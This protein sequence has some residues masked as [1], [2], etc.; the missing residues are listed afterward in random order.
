MG[1]SRR[2]P[3]LRSADPQ[4]LTT[5]P[6]IL[7]ITADAICAAGPIEGFRLNAY[8]ESTWLAYGVHRENAGV[9]QAFIDPNQEF[10][11]ARK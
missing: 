4:T 7:G 1:R 10:R 8:A 9:D 6:A 5:Q 3:W 11:D 2:S